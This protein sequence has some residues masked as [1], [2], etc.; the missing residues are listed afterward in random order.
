MSSLLIYVIIHYFYSFTLL[1]RSV[2][3]IDLIVC[4]SLVCFSRLG[5]RLFFIQ[6]IGFISNE[7]PS[8]KKVL[9]IGAGDTGQT[10]A[11]QI[12]Q[13]TDQ[14]IRL[15]GF[16]DDDVKKIGHR[17]HG[18]PVYG[19]INS[20]SNQKITFDEIFICVPSSTRPQMRYIVSACKNTNKPFKTL[21]S[22][23]NLIDGKDTISQLRDVS[24]NDLLGREEIQL[25]KNSIRNL[26]FGKRV[27]ITGSGG[28]IGSEL[29]RQCIVFNPS[30]LIMIDNSELN[31]FEIERE[32]LNIN[33]NILFKPVLC[34][35]R[36]N[37]LIKELFDEFKPQ[38]VFHAA[39]YKHVPIQ[40][41]FPWEAVKTNVFGTL[42]LVNSSIQNKVE[43][44]VLVS[45][46]KAVK[47]VNVMGATKRLAELITQSYNKLH[48]STAFIAVR[49]GNVLG[50]SGSVIPIFKEQIKAGGPVTVTDPEM[51]RYFMSIPEASQLILQAGA[52]GD[53]GEIFI[54]DMGDPIKI[55]DLASDLIR[56]SGYDT[57]DIP[58]RITGVRPGEKK[59]E[60]L[61]N[62]SENFDR[63]KHEKIFVLSN[64]QLSE[65]GYSTIIP[66]IE[67]L[68]ERMDELN[69]VKVRSML[70]SV[71]SE[72]KPGA[73]LVSESFKINKEENAKA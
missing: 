46:D 13:K 25:D 50:S 64:S 7:N 23:S 62:S 47:P 27:L 39:A 67:K 71:L 34:D 19:P 2:I 6:A 17:L 48:N 65:E 58:I 40:E 66:S 43:K 16:V 18:I 26:V 3:F 11:R 55:L 72:Y 8:V 68:K 36:D 5:I 22:L 52:L 37:F 44:F 69:P 53:E 32:C 63:T 30:V 60:E 38:I 4:T 41:K 51:E 57:E 21:P 73:D 15:V 10:M 54:L 9:I 70:A 31:L 42:N 29:V 12:L 33:S 1:P 20:I 45:T 35:I 49:F 56:L 59:T 28:S 24:I 14:N 61:S